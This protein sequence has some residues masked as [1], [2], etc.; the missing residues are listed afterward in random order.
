MKD[1]NVTV[2]V[3]EHG[4]KDA[5]RLLKNFGPVSKTDYFNVLVMR[6]DNIPALLAELSV[7]I[8]KEP[9]I[10]NILA[11]V[12]PATRTFNF[13]GPEEF[14]I[15]A[16][17]AILTWVPDLA[18][19]SFHV[20][21]HRRGFKRRLSTTSEERMLDH[22]LLDALVAKGTPGSIAFENYEAV[23]AVETV[24]QRAGLSL[25]KWEELERYPF[26]GFK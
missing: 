23:L 1:W 20:R 26:L 21:M 25:W 11:R 7:K 12:I 6:V 14:E 18:G 9:G 10:L 15:K 2:T 19:K 22:V 3:H 13:M 16:R 24:D 4:F 8:K 5:I 17:E